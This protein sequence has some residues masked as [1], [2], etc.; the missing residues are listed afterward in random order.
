MLLAIVLCFV[1]Q[2]NLTGMVGVDPYQALGLERGFTE[3]EINRAYR[4]Y[5]SERRHNTNPS[6]RRQRQLKEI[7]FAFNVLGNPS[8]RTLFEKSGLEY[9]SHTN[10]GVSGYASDIQLAMVQK[11]YGQIPIELVKNGGTIFFPV[12]FNLLD[13]Y[14][15]AKKNIYLSGLELCVCKKGKGQRCAKCRD[16]PVFEKVTK[17]TFELPAGAPP[18]YV[19][20]AENVYDEGLERAPHDIVFIAMCN[21]DPDSDYKRVGNELWM[22]HTISL[23]EAIRGQTVEIENIDENTINVPIGPNIGNN[24][25]VRVADKGFPYVG[26]QA[27]GDLVVNFE[28]GFPDKLSDSQRAEIMKLLPEDPTKY[29]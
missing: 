21:E 6:P 15:G 28:I 3:K 19:Q 13:F 2:F 27:A 1:Q 8:A 25:I 16:N 22:N 17:F 20:Y 7:E 26:E 18:F 11:V 14:K 5:I 12:E 9:L 29:E 10:F 4:R 23:S 24:G